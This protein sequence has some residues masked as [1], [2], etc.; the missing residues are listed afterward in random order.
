MNGATSWRI[1]ALP[2]LCIALQLAACGGAEGST[3]GSASPTPTSSPSPAPTPTATP[4]P[5]SA[6]TA[7]KPSPLS[8]STSF[9][10]TIVS[11]GFFSLP[12]SPGAY[13]TY[14]A[15]SNVYTLKGVPTTRPTTTG[16]A[17]DT[18]LPSGSPDPTE[19]RYEFHSEGVK[20]YNDWLDYVTHTGRSGHLYAYTALGLHSYT[21]VYTSVNGGTTR[22]G[23]LIVFGFPTGSG[24]VPTSGT[25]TYVLDGFDQGSELSAVASN[26]WTITLTFNFDLGTF[27]LSGKRSTTTED[28]FWTTV[29][30]GTISSTGSFT[31]GGNTIAGMIHI[32]AKRDLTPKPGNAQGPGRLSGTFDGPF[33]AAFFGP[34]AEEIGVVFKVDG[35]VTNGPNATPVS[36]SGGFLGHS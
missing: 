13:V 15:A 23:S 1:R 31:R 10:G 22:E 34:S 4:T 24:Q 3:S 9:G 17:P 19:T 21:S 30:T 5:T 18:S 29:D 36:N 28:A 12:T 14:D 25:R 33:S 6:F 2:S 32:D 20:I 8:T 26:G 11:G 35:T 27:V 7:V 16:Q